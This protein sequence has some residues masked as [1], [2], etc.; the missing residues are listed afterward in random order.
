VSSVDLWSILVSENVWGFGSTHCSSWLSSSHLNDRVQ[1]IHQR[2]KFTNR[3]SSWNCDVGITEQL[4]LNLLHLNRQV[5]VNELIN[6]EVA[7]VNSC[8][9][10]DLEVVLLEFHKAAF[11][12]KSVSSFLVSKEQL[13]ESVSEWRPID[14][15]AQLVVNLVI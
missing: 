2:G 4:R 10:T 14:I 3:S 7:G 13:G 6:S 5:V 12:S 11:G 15:L 8:A 9:H 1:I